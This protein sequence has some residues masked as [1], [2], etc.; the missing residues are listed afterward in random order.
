MTHL[1]P[2]ALKTALA[3]STAIGFVAAQARYDVFG[4]TC[5]GT[6]RVCGPVAAGINTDGGILQ[7]M[8]GVAGRKYA[9]SL[10]ASGDVEIGGLQMF[11]HSGCG[12]PHVVTMELCADAAG[13]PGALLASAATLVGQQP[14]PDWH[15][16]TLTSPVKVMNGQAFWV[17]FENT[18]DCPIML[19]VLTNGATCEHAFQDP[20]N[21]WTL[22]TGPLPWAFRVNGLVA[23][24]PA[25]TGAIASANIGLT[26]PDQTLP[27]NTDFAIPFD[28]VGRGGNVCG[29]WMMTNNHGATQPVSVT[30]YLWL[31]AGGKPGQLVRTGSLTIDTETRLYR[32][33]WA[34]YPIVR[35]QR[36]WF[37]WSNPSPSI[38]APFGEGGVLTTYAVKPSSGNVWSIGDTKLPWNYL[39]KMTDETGD[40]HLVLTPLGLPRLGDRFDVR[41]SF[42]PANA[43]AILWNGSS[44]VKWASM[45]LPFQFPGSY[46]CFVHVAW[47][48]FMLATV[49]D[50]LGNAAIPFLVPNDPILAGLQLHQQ[51]LV[52]DAL[53][54]PF[55]VTSSNGGTAV[56][57]Y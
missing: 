22:S 36:F 43:V 27:E 35:G 15:K 48:G 12:R 46:G 4:N 45:D 29:L 8:P 16:V 3:L 53:A 39:V 33:Y 1:A 28:S 37:G 30:S 25:C 10:K 57:G 38:T 18:A 7:N 42:A 34:G 19:P 51:W 56:L 41:L 24:P 32:S 11:T 54:N 49:A 44:N 50:G 23:A 14:V 2:A 26:V 55:G 52:L 21:V 6:G 31:D 40:E 9:I 5:V 17:C 13:L 20:S 47:D